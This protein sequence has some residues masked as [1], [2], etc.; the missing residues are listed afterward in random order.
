M[1]LRFVFCV[2]R[3]LNWF[4]MPD[5]SCDS[6]S[7]LDWAKNLE[8]IYF[9]KKKSFFKNA[10]KHVN[11]ELF[12]SIFLIDNNTR[13]ITCSKIP[14]ADEQCIRCYVLCY[15]QRPMFFG[16]TLAS[17]PPYVSA[18]AEGEWCRF[19][20]VH[21]YWNIATAQVWKRPC[22]RRDQTVTSLQF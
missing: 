20:T 7:W 9:S 5:P 18:R 3:I 6:V 4:V 8:N 21:K 11:L 19:F 16:A 12:Y 15:T 22:Q 2:W 1:K 10:L 13:R 14:W 17:H